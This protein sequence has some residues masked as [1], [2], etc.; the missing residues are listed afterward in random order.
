[1]ARALERWS[2][3]PVGC[4]R[5]R[6]DCRAGA[7]LLELLVTMAVMTLLGAALCGL[8]ITQLRVARSLM[9]RAQA[10]EAVRLTAAVLQGEARRLTAADVRAIAGDSLAIRAFRGLGVPC[11]SAGATVHVR[12]RGDRL[13]EPAKD[14]VL[15]VSAAGAGAGAGAAALLDSR[16][17]AHA[18]CSAGPG[19]RVL[20]LRLAEALDS[21]AVVL[22]FESG[23]YF[24]SS[25]ALRYRLGAE[26]RQPL[27][28]ELLL[29]GSRF[30]TADGGRIRLR[31]VTRAAGTVELA[32][33][34]GSAALP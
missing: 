6:T 21:A 32:A 20:Q 22:V 3:A 34:I 18:M 16:P 23:R 29:A 9:D 2:S 33:P 1:M 28:A 19:E 25:R 5:T 7:T 24:I 4:G 10:G 14:S 15:A 30:E 31:L 8:L 27:T 26:G 13:P 11:H 12:Y 17:G